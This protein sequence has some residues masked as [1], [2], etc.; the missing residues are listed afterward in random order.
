MIPLPEGEGLRLGKRS[1]PQ[2][3]RVRGFS[4]TGSHKAP[5]PFAQ[6]RSLALSGAQALSLWEKDQ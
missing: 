2:A 1:A 6:D 4:L 5:H 3:E